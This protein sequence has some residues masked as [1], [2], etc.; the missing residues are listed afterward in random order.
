[1]ERQHHPGNRRWG[2][3]GSGA[4][5]CSAQRHSDSILKTKPDKTKTD[6]SASF[7]NPA[8]QCLAIGISE[9]YLHRAQFMQINAGLMASQE[10][11]I[12]KLKNLSKVP[13][14]ALWKARP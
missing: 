14:A 10:A 11:L 3:C 12:N 4:F 8:S 13:F 1:M 5:L 9:M 6:L 2:I 7:A